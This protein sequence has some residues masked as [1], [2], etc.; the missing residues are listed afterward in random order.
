MAACAGY[1]IARPPHFIQISS[2]RAKKWQIRKDKDME[3]VWRNDEEHEIEKVDKNEKHPT[4]HKWQSGLA[5]IAYCM[6]K[7]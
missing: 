7:T 2:R 4:F 1:P 5:W 3:K 6:G